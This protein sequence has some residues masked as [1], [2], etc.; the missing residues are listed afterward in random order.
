MG[1]EPIDGGTLTLIGAFTGSCK[2]NAAGASIR[3]PS[4]AERSPTD[5]ST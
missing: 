1:A 2:V 5:C 4:V 3:V